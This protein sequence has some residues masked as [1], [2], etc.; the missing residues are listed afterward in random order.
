MILSRQDMTEKMG[1]NEYMA[2][3][4]AMWRVMCRRCDAVAAQLDTASRQSLSLD[5]T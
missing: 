5:V 1:W 3:R 2:C 4:S